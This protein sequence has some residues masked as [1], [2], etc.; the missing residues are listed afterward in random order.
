M[1]DVSMRQALED[2]KLLGTLLSGDSWLAW[3]ILLIAAMG[4]ALTDDE[5]VIFKKLTGREREP[6]E[7]CFILLVIAGRRAGKSRA[8]ACLITYL[9]VF[10]TH[11]AKLAPGEK[12][13]ILCLAQNRQQAGVVFG[14]VRGAFESVALLAELV[15][16]ETKESLELTN[17]IEIVVRAASY[18]GLRGITA[19]AV[20]A[21]EACFWH[22]EDSGSA[23]SDTEII[24]AVMPSLATTGGLLVIISSPYSKRGEAYQIF[25]KNFGPLGDSKIL[26]AQGAS[27][28][29]NSEL[30]QR[31]VDAAM[32]RDA[33]WASSEY[34]GLWRTDI[35]AFIDRETIESR[36]SRGVTV[37]APLPQFDYVAAVDPSGGSGADSFTMAVCHLEEGTA[38][39]DCVLERRP[40]LSPEAVTEEFCATLR[41]YGIQSVVG[42]RYAGLWPT[43][44]FAVN[45][46]RYEPA[47]MNRSEAYLAFLPMLTSGKVDL[48]D[49]LRLINQFAGLERRTARSGK[50]SIDSAPNQHEDLANAA[51]LALV[52][53]RAPAR[54]TP[55][56]QT[57]TFQIGGGN[58]SAGNP[59]QIHYSTRSPEYWASIG[60]FHPSDRTYW[61][62]RG[63]YKPPQTMEQ[64]IEQ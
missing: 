11:G 13:T 27:R 41:E 16:N 21:D 23:N 24:G 35:A 29:F 17:G 48:L 28:D 31:V 57:G 44:R 1:A 22:S 18:R 34:L 50:D 33:A 6:G 51:A 25:A 39:L 5:R 32:E 52:S 14:Y 20:I 63:I 30:P 53:A 45:G 59:G 26:V 7:R 60:I 40:P 12:A 55:V 46:I 62:S 4:E 56:A 49:N 47:A 54:R 15:A 2:P 10:F 3:R 42:D 58:W 61:I 43:E 36:V 9:S 38:V 8:I 37:R 64:V 19:I